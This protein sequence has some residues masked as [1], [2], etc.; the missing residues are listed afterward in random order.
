MKKPVAWVPIDGSL[1]I[2]EDITSNKAKTA[3][4]GDANESLQKGDQSRRCKN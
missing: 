1:T 4:V 2:M 3:A